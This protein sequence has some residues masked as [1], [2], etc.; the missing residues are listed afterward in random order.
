M[1]VW[2]I[3]AMTPPQ[4]PLILVAS[5]SIIPFPFSLAAQRQVCGIS[6]KYHIILQTAKQTLIFTLGE[7]CDMLVCH[8]RQVKSRTSEC[9]QWFKRQKKSQKFSVRMPVDSAGS[10]QLVG[11]SQVGE[12]CSSS[13]VFYPWF[14]LCCGVHSLCL[15][16]NK[17]LLMFKVFL[18]E[19]TLH[20]QVKVAHEL[21]HNVL[22]WK[23]PSSVPHIT[24]LHYSPK[25][26]LRKELYYI[27]SL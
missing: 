16:Q 17:I 7:I 3:V 20:H 26:I 13:M 19:W 27:S 1:A 2:C 4:H 22:G 9:C 14:V 10:F 8:K 18:W 15:S 24:G 25:W 12:G 23:F 21:S 11:I 5:A 6:Q